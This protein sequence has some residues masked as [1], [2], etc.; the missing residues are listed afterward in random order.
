[1]A[2]ITEPAVID[3][4]TGMLVEIVRDAD[5]GK[6]IGKNERYPE[7]EQEAE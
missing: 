6:I 7:P 1:M 2:V 3:E 4:Q 5:T